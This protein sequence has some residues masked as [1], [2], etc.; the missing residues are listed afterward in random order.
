MGMTN[1]TH[2]RSN[3]ASALKSA[4][5]VEVLVTCYDNEDFDQFTDHTMF[6]EIDTLYT[7]DNGCEYIGG[8]VDTTDYDV[9]ECTAD[10]TC[11]SS[12]TTERFDVPIS[13]IDE[14]TFA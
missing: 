6:V 12:H 14:L 13:D 3:I 9:H 10:D 4:T 8:V 7:A 5:T 11:L 2:H 1:T